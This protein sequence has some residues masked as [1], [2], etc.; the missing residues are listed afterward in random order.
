M[1]SIWHHVACGE[2]W[3]IESLGVDLELNVCRVHMYSNS[4]I[5]L[6]VYIYA[7]TSIFVVGENRTSLS[8]VI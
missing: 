6:T 4:D 7:K 5:Y 2:V 1:A 3:F 8:A